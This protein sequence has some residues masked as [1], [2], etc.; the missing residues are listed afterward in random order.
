MHQPF[1]RFTMN[2]LL[3]GL[4]LFC[5]NSHIKAQQ[6]EN[7]KNKNLYWAD[8]GVGL[9]FGN[10]NEYL[11]GTVSANYTN[12]DMLYKLRYTR[13]ELFEIMGSNNKHFNEIGGMIGIAKTKKLVRLSASGGL[14]FVT[15]KLTE[16]F[17]YQEGGT[18]TVRG[19]T[20]NIFALCVPLEA[21]VVLTPV[22]FAGIGL[23]VNGNI[24]LKVPLFGAGIKLS[25]G[26][27]QD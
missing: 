25:I 20:E 7:L 1:P 16:K 15:G 3:F 26:K 17:V 13:Y 23:F 14:G 4:F 12:N 24:N 22:K 8:V 19:N 18:T 2:L 5:M 21:E 6:T 27:L 11:S 9:N 10:N